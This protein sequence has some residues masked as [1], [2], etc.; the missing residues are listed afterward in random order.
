MSREG[1]SLA[2][3]TSLRIGGPAAAL[4][5]PRSEDELLAAWREARARGD[6]VAVLGRGSN[7]IFRDE[8]FPGAVLRT[9]EACRQLEIT[10]AQGRLWRRRTR[11]YAGCSVTL[12]E[13]VR[14]CIDHRLAA[15][16]YLY[17]VPGNVGGAIAMNAGTGKDE[18]RCISESVLR[19][20]VFDGERVRWL[21]A[22]DCGFVFRGSAF[23]EHDW[24]ILGAE[25][26]YPCCPRW[27]S[28]RQV[29]ERMAFVRRTQDTAHPNAGSVFK[30]GYR[31]FPELSGFRI[32]DAA[33]S[34][35]S[36]NWIVNLGNATCRDVLAL[37]AHAGQLHRDAGL[38]EPVVEIHIK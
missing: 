4:V 38:P 3:L 2:A 9:T 32:G 33:F 26:L 24:L 27:R 34:E 13:L 21:A 15:P 25:F 1:P 10:S 18:G 5:T 29:R 16:A 14:F 37:I 20:K 6:P 7:T 31:H 12:Q 8:G 22:S 19:V 11:V 35:K 28:R 36:V 23:L 30:T 17:S